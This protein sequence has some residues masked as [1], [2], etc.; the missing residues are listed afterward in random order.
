[1]PFCWIFRSFLIFYMNAKKFLQ[2]DLYTY[3]P[4]LWLDLG[5]FPDVAL[6]GPRLWNLDQRISQESCMTTGQSGGWDLQAEQAEFLCLNRAWK[7]NLCASVE[8]DSTISCHMK[9]FC[10]TSDRIYV[11]PE[12]KIINKCQLFLLLLYFSFMLSNNSR[13]FKWPMIQNPGSYVSARTTCWGQE[14]WR[15]LGKACVD[16]TLGEGSKKS[17]FSPS[18][19]KAHCKPFPGRESQKQLNQMEC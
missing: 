5:K 13:V 11:N 16:G 12:M 3:L 19:G 15:G 10:R 8:L 7:I 9:L 14:N 1:M 4:P 17:L 18:P 2:A 6:P